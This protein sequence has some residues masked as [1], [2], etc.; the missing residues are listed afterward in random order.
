VQRGWYGGHIQIIEWLNQ[1]GYLE[2]HSDIEFY[3]VDHGHLQALVWLLE[4]GFN[5]LDTFYSS[6]AADRG[7]RHVLEWIMEQGLVLSDD[8]YLCAAA[9][10]GEY[11]AVLQ[12]LRAL[13]CP[14]DAATCT[15]AAMMEIGSQQEPTE[16]YEE[17]LNW[18]RA[19][20]ET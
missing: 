15:A 19:L 11:V 10:S 6:M 20:G 1:R 9:A 18:L 5:M 16:S 4:H 2:E 13:G 12:W 7:H 8:G 3:A 17:V 14:F